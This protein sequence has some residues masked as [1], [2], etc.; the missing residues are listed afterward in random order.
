MCVV[1][2][3]LNL[4][5]EPCI[6]IGVDGCGL[7]RRNQKRDGVVF[8]VDDDLRA[9]ADMSQHSGKVSN[10]FSLRD[11]DHRHR[12]IIPPLGWDA[13]PMLLRFISKL[14]KLWKK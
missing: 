11:V 3:F 5:A 9:C 6:V 10:R 7:C 2:S 4:R 8:A 14:A 13:C 1:E 12:K